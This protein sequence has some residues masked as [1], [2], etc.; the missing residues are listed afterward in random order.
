MIPKIA[1]LAGV[2]GPVFNLTCLSAHILG[3][4]RVPWSTLQGSLQLVNKFFFKKKKVIA[5]GFHDCHLEVSHNCFSYVT[6]PYFD[7]YSRTV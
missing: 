4:C 7:T 2:I 3:V 6:V 1:P 5:S